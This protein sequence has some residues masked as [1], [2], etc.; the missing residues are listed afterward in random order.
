MGLTRIGARIRASWERLPAV[1]LAVAAALVALPVLASD[2]EAHVRGRELFVKCERCHELNPEH[3]NRIG[4]NLFD[5]VGRKAGA[6][7]DFRYSRGMKAAAEDGLVWTV[8]NID[9][10]L[11]SPRS[12]VRRTSMSFRGLDDAGERA[13]IIAFLQT[14]T[15]EDFA[16]LPA[17]SDPAGAEMGASAIAL[18]GDIDYGEYLSTECV[19]CHQ[20]SGADDGIPAIVGWPKEEFIRA[21]FE[22]KTNVRDHDVMKLVTSSLGDEEIAALAAYFGQVGQ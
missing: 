13:D 7:D 16:S 11:Q 17:T 12:V 6:L 14:I 20:T 8:E 18:E 21:L 15:P 9:R 5:V 4:P 1:G 3:G 19:T 2:D 10:F 22:Y